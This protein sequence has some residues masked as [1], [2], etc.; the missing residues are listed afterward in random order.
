MN[1]IFLLLVGLFVC[2]T[3][4]NAKKEGDSSLG[5]STFS[6]EVADSL[7][8]EERNCIDKKE[9]II[10]YADTIDYMGEINQIIFEKDTITYTEDIKGRKSLT[11]FNNKHLRNHALQNSKYNIDSMD[12]VF[13]LN[14]LE[15]CYLKNNDKIVIIKTKP[16]NWVG[17][18]TSFSYFQLINSEENTLIEFIREEE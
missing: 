14:L 6:K 5:N 2:C 10:S 7:L 18:M 12:L 15:I 8:N 17:R 1:N 13:D 11:L 16:T 3:T 4:K 9:R